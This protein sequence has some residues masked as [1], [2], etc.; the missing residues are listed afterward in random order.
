MDPAQPVSRVTPADRIRGDPTP[1]MVREQ[2]I[3][4]DGLWAGLVRTEARMVSGWHHHGDYDTSIYV[5]HGSMRMESGPGGSQVIEAGPGDFLFV[6]KARSTGRAIPGPR[7][8]MSLS[9]ARD[10][11]PVS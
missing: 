5:V 11:A 10:A 6:P 3:V 4:V 7:R 9:C 8:A 1:G 2:A